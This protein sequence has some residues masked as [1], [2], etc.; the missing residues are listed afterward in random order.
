MFSAS[1]ILEP[2]VF[3][4]QFH[5]LDALI[6]AAA[7]ATPG[8][9]G[10]ETLKST[11]GKITHLIYYWETL[12]ALKAFSSH[13]KHLEAKRQYQKWYKGFHIVISQILKSYGDGALD[14]F[15]PNQR[16]QRP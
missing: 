9:L 13:P 14:H 8:F 6:E 10:Y 7:Q 1:F 12:A 3:D 2:G 16:S 11:D 5:D 15:T 4:Q